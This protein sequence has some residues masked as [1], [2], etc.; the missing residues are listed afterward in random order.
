MEKLFCTELLIGEK[1]LRKLRESFA[2]VIGIG[3]VGGYATEALARCGVGRIR[4]VD[5]DKIKATNFNRHLCAVDANLGKP[6]VL[7][8]QERIAGIRPDCRVEA[9]EAFAAEETIGGLLEGPPDVVLDAVDAVGP[10]FQIL[11]EC[12]RK[13]IPVISSMGAALRTD[14]FSVK[15]GDL[16]KTSGCP[17]ARRLRGKLRKAGIGKGIFCVY[18]DTPVSQEPVRVP[19]LLNEE[20]DYR[21]GRPRRKLGS[22]PTLPGIFGLALAHFAL[23]FLLTGRFSFDLPVEKETEA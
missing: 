16:F 15:A 8:A 9:V 4:L 10:K 5:F 18:S 13:K 14:V 1:N 7:A 17:L 6:K 19:L 21:R 3:A 11:A 20:D 22:L 12:S 23:G 2:L